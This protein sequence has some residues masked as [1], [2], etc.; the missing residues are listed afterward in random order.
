[1]VKGRLLEMKKDNLD[2]R[3]KLIIVL[4]LSSLAIAYKDFLVLL[5]I[6]FISISLGFLLKINLISI[7]FRIRRLVGLLV[8]IGFIQSILT[9]T[10]TPIVRI[11][12]IYLITDYGI[13]K[14]MEFILRISIIISSSAIITTSSSREIVQA[15]I[16]LK[17]P[18]EIAFMASI[19]VRFLPLFMEEMKDMIIA[20]QLRGL[21]LK[22]IRLVEKLKVY[23]YIFLP[24]IINSFLK[25]KDLGAAM[26]M[27][28]LRAYT[29]RTSYMILRMNLRDYLIIAFSII[30]SLIFIKLV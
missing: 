2:P 29:T 17:I 26:E 12:G 10:G 5:S 27:R 21:D 15:L 9:R 30:G 13:E 22:K 23:K 4:L 11:G 14:A 16:Q 7:V 24:I 3:T 19:G 28:G 8:A 6:L 18:Y 25:A 20:I 1:M